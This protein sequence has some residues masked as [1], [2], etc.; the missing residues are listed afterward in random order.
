MNTQRFRMALVAFALTTGFACAGAGE[1]A[2]MFQAEKRS[3]GLY[4]AAIV[5]ADPFAGEVLDQ[6]SDVNAVVT[7]LK[8]MRTLH[9][10]LRVPSS[11]PVIVAGERGYVQSAIESLSRRIKSL[12][13]EYRKFDERSRTWGT[14]DAEYGS[15]LAAYLSCLR[16]SYDRAQRTERLQ[17]EFLRASGT[18]T[19]E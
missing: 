17:V 7:V 8:A 10:E 12:E 13:D 4:R 16:T 6:A 5:R 1:I 14:V 15:R 18:A 11:T 19:A 9:R 3:L 2:G